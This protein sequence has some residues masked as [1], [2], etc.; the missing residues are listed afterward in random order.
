MLALQLFAE[1]AD[2][3][4]TED[5]SDPWKFPHGADYHREE[6]AEQQEEAV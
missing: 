5:H 6:A 3:R 2:S 1:L 4:E